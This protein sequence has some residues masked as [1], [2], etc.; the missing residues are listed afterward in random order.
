MTGRRSPSRSN[1]IGSAETHFP[2]D[3]RAEAHA[4]KGRAKAGI[5]PAEARRAKL[6]QAAQER[7][8]TVGRLLAKYAEVL[9]GHDKLR[10]SGK[11][12]ACQGITASSELLRGWMV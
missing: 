6:A 1:T 3:A 8:A 4:L 9:P 11:L 7:G 5:D 10:G 12:R 2:D